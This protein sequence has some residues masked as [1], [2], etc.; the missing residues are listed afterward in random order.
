MN[1]INHRNLLFAILVALIILAGYFQLREYSLL[2]VSQSRINNHLKFLDILKNRSKNLTENDVQLIQ[3][4]MTFGYIN[5]IFKLPTDYLKTTLNISNSNYLV[6]SLYKY[7]KSQNFV[8]NDFLT[9]VRNAV[10]DFLAPQII[11]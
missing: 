7:A 9:S 10:T 5:T 2:Q 4:W 6:L 3:S 8:A 1:N 11:I